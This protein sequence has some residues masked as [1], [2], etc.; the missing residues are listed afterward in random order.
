MEEDRANILREM[1]VC[2]FCLSSEERELTNI[3]DKHGMDTKHYVPLPLQIMACIAIEVFKNDGM[4]QL[5]CNYCRKLTLQAYNFKTNCKKADDALKLFLATGQFSKPY[6]QKVEEIKTNRKQPERKTTIV[7]TF[8]PAEPS[9]S[10]RMKMED[11]TEIITLNFTSADDRGSVHPGENENES[12]LGYEDNRDR[13]DED[14]TLE[15]EDY[16]NLDEDDNPV[17]AVLKVSQVKTDCFPCPHCDRT[18]PLKQLLDLHL[19]NHDRERSYECSECTR[20]FF[21]KYDLQKHLQTHNGD[22]PF[23][24]IICNK[25]FSRESLLRRHEKIHVD[26]PKY[27][28]NQCDKTF[29][30]KQYL[31]AHQEK[32]KKKRPFTCQVCNKSFVFKQGLERHEVVHSENKPHKCNY[33]EASF[34]SAIKLTRHITSHAGLRPY[35]CKLCGRTFLL[36]HHLTRHMR[37]HYAMQSS[38]P[39]A[40]IGQ[41]KC[42][43]CSMSFRRKDSLI[44]HSAIHSMVNLR[45]VICNTTFKTANMV[46]EHITTHLTGLPHP[47]EKCDYSFE[48]S[49]Q[50][51]EHELKHAEMEYEEQIEKE[52]ISEARQQQ[53][54]NMDEY[55]EGEITEYTITDINN[56]E[57]IPTSK[58]REQTEREPGEDLTRFGHFL[59]D[60]IDSELE[61][62]DDGA[63]DN[64][65]TSAQ[66]QEVEEEQELEPIKP[67]VRQEGTKVYKR[68]APLQRKVPQ[69]V[70]EPLKLAPLEQINQAETQIENVNLSSDIGSLPSKKFVNM[71]VGDKV[72]RVQKFIVTKEEMKAMAKQ[73]ILEMKG[74][75]VVL[76]NPGQPILNATLKPIQKVDIESLID[77]KSNAKQQ[78]KKYQARPGLERLSEQ[79]SLFSDKSQDKN[80]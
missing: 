30:T 7:N 43:I 23:D 38:S 17:N 47:C 12:I 65:K 79:N 51:E 67:I 16:S 55:E 59:K 28:C 68:K 54:E 42:D 69:I 3:Y 6:I 72:V 5:I 32:H 36:S 33:C 34:T 77:K 44:N 2:R 80:T 41:H 29:L 27:V 1:K 35:P 73:G 75:Q 26:V 76:K 18:F 63:G 53:E 49:E 52:V 22:K 46:K 64:E 14:T 10:K 25:S 15:E 13:C 71:K 62:N 37:S 40:A 57:V 61:D 78:I 45:C 48:T 74:G 20:K 21:T 70:R 56:P 8:A 11:G 60:E 58:H 19:P 66:Q 39:E 50:L 31:D 9:K 24:C 4:P